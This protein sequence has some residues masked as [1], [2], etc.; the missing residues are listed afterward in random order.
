MCLIFITT[1]SGNPL[2]TAAEANK[3]QHCPGVSALYFV[4]FTLRYLRSAHIVFKP[5]Y[6]LSGW[7][8][9][10]TTL[11]WISGRNTEKSQYVMTSWC[12]VEFSSV[13]CWISGF[14]SISERYQAKTLLLTFER[15][16][17]ISDTR[18]GLTYLKNPVSGSSLC[19]LLNLCCNAFTL[20]FKRNLLN[21]F[22]L[23]G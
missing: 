3:W 22:L 16:V 5:K 20:K 13:S 15:Q 23:Y 2:G 21:Y 9:R 6:S 10:E 19:V 1:L 4:L 12:F 8:W 18:F 14:E 11:F 7:Y 17:V